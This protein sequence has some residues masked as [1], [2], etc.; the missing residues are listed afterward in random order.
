MNIFCHRLAL[1]LS[2][3]SVEH[4]AACLV[5]SVWRGWQIRRK[6]G[7]QQASACCIQSLWR[8]YRARLDVAEQ[9]TIRVFDAAALVI[10]KHA[11]GY[12]ARVTHEVQSQLSQSNPDCD[13]FRLDGNVAS[14][15][16]PMLDQHARVE[17]S[18]VLCSLVLRKVHAARAQEYLIEARTRRT[19]QMDAATVLTTLCR[20][21]IAYRLA[22]KLAVQREAEYRE[23]FRSDPVRWCTEWADEL[24]V[25]DLWSVEGEAFNGNSCSS[26]TGKDATSDSDTVEG[27]AVAKT[28]DNEDHQE[29]QPPTWEAMKS[30]GRRL[31]ALA[32]VASTAAS[33]AASTLEPVGICDDSDSDNDAGQ[34]SSS[35]WT[36]KQS[37]DPNFVPR[38]GFVEPDRQVCHS[39]PDC[40]C[41]FNDELVSGQPIDALL[42]QAGRLVAEER[43]RC[44]EKRTRWH[45]IALNSRAE[46]SLSSAEMNFLLEFT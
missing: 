11:R 29:Q 16:G 15:Q 45:G 18:G 46:I 34:W 1:L 40:D 23:R 27:D 37:R 38:V 5:Q 20:R 8:G 30:G 31:L 9:R 10:Q 13:Q 25:E 21:R 12:V 19:L 14:Q 22:A 36:P 7:H 2:N 41:G 44:P 32:A 24:A 33:I 28:D 42:K 35:R 6:A 43:V 17:A 4:S 39:K 26:D 3:V